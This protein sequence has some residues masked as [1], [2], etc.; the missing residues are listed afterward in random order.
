MSKTNLQA[1]WIKWDEVKETNIEDGRTL[2]LSN[3]LIQKLIES[4]GDMAFLKITLP[5]PE[6]KESW[7]YKYR[8]LTLK[9]KIGKW[10]KEHIPYRDFMF[11]SP[12]ER[13]D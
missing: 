2:L 5:T 8:R 4:S 1:K 6:Q 13:Y 11:W 12:V 7:I 3:K 9:R 10:I